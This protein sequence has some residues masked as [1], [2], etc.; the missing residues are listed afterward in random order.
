MLLSKEIESMRCR[1]FFTTIGCASIFA[2]KAGFAFANVSVNSPDKLEPPRIQALLVAAENHEKNL[3]NLDVAWQA[4]VNYCEASRLG[5]LE[6]QYRLGMLYRFGKGVPTNQTYSGALFSLAS[7]QGHSDATKM[8]DTIKLSSSELPPC[9]TSEVLP[10]RPIATALNLPSDNIDIERRIAALSDAK[11][12]IID[13][14]DTIAEGHQIDPKLVLAIIAVE[15]N[16]NTRAQ[17]PKNAMGLMQLIPDTADRFNIKNA[18]DAS[19]NIKGGI[20]Y[21]R[22]LLSYYHGD[23]RLVAA[24]YN[25]GERAVD[26]YKGIP[27]YP[28]TRKYVKRV[29]ELYQHQSHPYDEKITDPS[30]I[31]IRPG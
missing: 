24:A 20:R 26:R 15:S 7:S 3:N 16:F 23:I 5:S 29:L 9:V 27:P 10:E 14:V 25:A 18:F 19:Q 12:W 6:A 28:E 13:L 22:W 2:V 31:I 11:K 21:L 30:P 8:L 1:I 4:A 17:S